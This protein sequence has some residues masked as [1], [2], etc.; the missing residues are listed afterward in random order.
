MLLIYEINSLR[1]ELKVARDR[2]NQYE[3]SLG[4]N[5]TSHGDTAEMRFKLQAAIEDRDDLDIAHENDLELREDMIRAQQEEIDSL[6]TKI[7]KVNE[8]IHDTTKLGGMGG[9]PA[10]DHIKSVLSTG[11]VLNEA[12]ESKKGEEGLQHQPSFAASHKQSV[13]P[14]HG[15]SHS[16]Q[17]GSSHMPRESSSQVP[18]QESS[19]AWTQASKTPSQS[20]SQTQMHSQSQ[21][22]SNMPSSYS[23]QNE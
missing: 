19:V 16:P 9:G 10:I 11:Q 5:Q 15:S 2:L 12:E 4:L 1:R 23:N 3:T 8:Y 21:M 14:A 22:P 7:L 17:H 18:A 13:G 20:Q 6:S